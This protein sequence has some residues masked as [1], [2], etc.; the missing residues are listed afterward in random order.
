MYEEFP[1][2]CNKKDIGYNCSNDETGTNLVSKEEGSIFEDLTTEAYGKY[3]L[4]L[5][6]YKISLDTKKDRIYAEDTL[7]HVER[8][9]YINGYTETI[10][11]NVRTYQLQGIW[12]EDLL[13]VYVGINAFKYWSTYGGADRNTP[14]LNESF[15]ARI[16]DIIYL[17]LNDTFYE[18]RDVKYYTQPFGLAKHTYTLSLKVYKDVKFTV[19]NHE[20]LWA[21]DPIWGVAT[22]A[23]ESQY[24]IKD[25]LML[26]EF[27]Y[28]DSL[29]E[30]NN[31]NRINVLYNKNTISEEAFNELHQAIEIVKHNVTNTIEDYE[32]RTTKLE[33]DTIELEKKAETLDSDKLIQQIIETR[34]LIEQLNAEICQFKL[35]D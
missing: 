19:D 12:G 25:I 28:I 3:G 2:L 15:E 10:P 20:T 21:D 24:A 8:A 7:Q 14:E 18:I 16:G 35:T 22:N 5:T 9:F 1:W 29:V 11:P 17:P 30:S 13:T 6:Y 27:Y 4:K 34:K 26:N 33:Q 32:N 23:L 31:V